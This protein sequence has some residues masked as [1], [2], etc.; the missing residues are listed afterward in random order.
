M[1]KPDVCSLRGGG[2][3]ATGLPCFGFNP[4]GAK[5][6]HDRMLTPLCRRTGWQPDYNTEIPRVL[7]PPGV[8]LFEQSHYSQA[9]RHLGYS[10]GRI[11]PD[12]FKRPV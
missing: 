3:S 4:D 12:A 2:I 8:F 10:T 5:I 6:L 1:Y 7:R 11:R 9:R